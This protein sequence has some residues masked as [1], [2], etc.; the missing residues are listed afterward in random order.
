MAKK[1]YGI[2]LY[3]DLW[4][5]VKVRAAEDGTTANAIV[6]AALDAWL[7]E[8]LARAIIDLGTHDAANL[9]NVYRRP[10]LPPERTLTYEKD[11]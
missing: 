4:R 3:P 11:E 5:R 1:L 9:N 2:R 7:D 6:S 8:P 10:A